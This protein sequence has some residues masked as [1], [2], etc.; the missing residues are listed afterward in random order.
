MRLISVIG[1]LLFFISIFNVHALADGDG[2][3]KKYIPVSMGIN[4]NEPQAQINTVT[5]AQ[6]MGDLAKSFRPFDESIYHR[7]K[8]ALETRGVGAV[9]FASEDPDPDSVFIDEYMPPE[10][11]SHYTIN[12][13][14]ADD[15][16]ETVSFSLTPYQALDDFK[17]RGLVNRFAQ[18]RYR[19]FSEFGVTVNHDRTV[20]LKKGSYVYTTG[21]ESTV[22]GD[23][24]DGIYPLYFKGDVEVDVE[25]FAE[26]VACPARYETANKCLD[27]NIPKTPSKEGIKLTFTANSDTHLR[28]FHLILPTVDHE[29]VLNGEI[30]FNPD[31]LDYIKPFST[32]RVMNMMLASPR[33][34]FE[35][36]TT[37]VR[38]RDVYSVPKHEL[39][40]AYLKHDVNIR[41]L[42]MISDTDLALINRESLKVDELLKTFE[43]LKNDDNEIIYTEIEVEEIGAM[44]SELLAEDD[45]LNILTMDYRIAQSKKA[46]KPLKEKLLVLRKKTR[47]FNWNHVNPNEDYGNCLMK[48]SRTSVNRARLNDQFWG[49]SY[50]TPEERW[51]GFP[52][53]VIVELV[54]RTKSNVWI[55]IPH[56]ASIYYVSDIAKYFAEHLHKDS[57]VFLEL[58]NEVWNGGFASQKYFIGLANHRY[59]Y[60][61]KELLEEFEHYLRYSDD[62][63]I[64]YR[65]L[66]ADYLVFFDKYKTEILDELEDFKS[67]KHSGELDVLADGLRF[68]PQGAALAQ[69][70]Q[71]MSNDGND[72]PVLPRDLQRMKLVASGAHFSRLSQ[73]VLHAHRDR[74]CDVQ[75]ENQYVGTDR[76]IENIRY[77]KGNFFEKMAL[78][79]PHLNAYWLGYTGAIKGQLKIQVE[80][81]EGNYKDAF[82]DRYEYVKEHKSELHSPD[83]VYHFSGDE[84]RDLQ[85]DLFK[86]FKRGWNTR[87]NE[88]ISFNFDKNADIYVLKNLDRAYK[89]M[90]QMAYVHRLDDVAKI[91][92]DS[93]V[94][95]KNLIVTLATKQNNPHLTQSMLSYAKKTGSIQRIDAVASPA[96]FFGCFGDLKV[97]D[98][99]IK[100][101]KFGPCKGISKG[102][103]N[104]KTAK[105]II[106]IIKNPANPKGTEAVRKQIIAH[107]AMIKKNDDRI[108]LVA[109]EGG[110]HLALANMGRTQRKYIDH[111]PELKAEKL[112]LFQEAIEHKGMGELT[113][114]LYQV[115]LD[116]GGT[117]FNNFYMPQ[118]F[119][120][121]GSFGLS[122]SLSDK[123][124]PRYVTASEQAFVFEKVESDRQAKR[125]EQ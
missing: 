61:V 19:K 110:H 104:A 101:H 43:A 9:K 98:K 80:D 121:W 50:I 74:T 48:Y 106:D 21:L 70:R 83:L 102:V 29:A 38:G 113:K 125:G 60:Y 97:G 58:S 62:E 41:L 69:I 14:P 93:G 114:D 71:Y 10:E 11:E 84:I 8:E 111:H 46:Q 23:V 20:L 107:K 26:F 57:K 3:A 94:N 51:R 116:E 25:G 88:D 33:A 120:E 72:I 77:K 45:Y 36:V 30:V 95:K 68:N 7:V 109:Y 73:F 79:I 118:T 117:V 86:E 22:P 53:E 78:K 37:F 96:Y 89:N 34:P 123:E 76:F 2:S 91:W 5:H 54:N 32:F 27:I 82:V 1:L 65:N 90:A 47:E 35:C 108:Q 66:R 6:M 115:W 39:E 12:R 63:E 16:L 13:D 124:T 85:A 17:I 28:S 112:A 122:L 119:H 67:C 87:I 105:D 99:T 92:L 55:N 56:D 49:S 15:K 103:L 44:I 81:N 24:P 18:K 75:L 42:E 4:L 59:E 64:A 52:Y 100:P 40:T 31:Y